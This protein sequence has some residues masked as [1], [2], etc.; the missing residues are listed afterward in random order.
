MFKRLSGPTYF[1]DLESLP[2]VNACT[3]PP[4]SAT[5]FSPGPFSP[6]KASFQRGL[7]EPLRA[8]AS[9]DPMAVGLSIP[10]GFN[11]QTGM[12]TASPTLPFFDPFGLLSH[13][14]EDQ[15]L[16]LPLPIS[17]PGQFLTEDVMALFSA[18][19]YG[20][21]TP[22]PLIAPDPLRH[23]PPALFSRF[24]TG[25]A[26][27]DAQWEVIALWKQDLDQRIG[28]GQYAQVL[29]TTREFFDRAD[30]LEIA[31]KA[32][33]FGIHLVSCEDFIDFSKTSQ[34]LFSQSDILGDLLV[35][36]NYHKVSGNKAG[37]S[38]ILRIMIKLLVGGV[39]LDHEIYP[40]W[41]DYSSGVDYAYQVSN[42]RQVSS[43]EFYAEWLSKSDEAF[44]GV[45]YVGT[46]A[47]NLDS[48]LVKRGSPYL[49][50]LAENMVHDFRETFQCYIHKAR[51]FEDPSQFPKA[52]LPHS[53]P[54]LKQY[55]APIALH[56]GI[57]RASISQLMLYKTETEACKDPHQFVIKNSITT[58]VLKHRDTI[59]KKSRETA[60]FRAIP[61][62]E[63]GV[64]SWHGV[65]GPFSGNDLEV[66]QQLISAISSSILFCDSI[67]IEFLYDRTFSQRTEL[68][69]MV[70]LYL[71]TWFQY[72]VIDD[73]QIGRIIYA[74]W[75]IKDPDRPT[76]EDPSALQKEA[77]DIAR[78]SRNRYIAITLLELGST[79]HRAEITEEEFDTKLRQAN[80]QLLADDGAIFP[81]YSTNT[82][83]YMTVLELALHNHWSPK[84][85]SYF[86][87]TTD[88]F[89]V[90]E[91]DGVK[92][93]VRYPVPAH[94]IQSL[95]EQPATP[96]L[97]RVLHLI[98]P[99]CGDI[100]STLQDCHERLH[101]SW[102]SY[103]ETLQL[104]LHLEK[105]LEDVLKFLRIQDPH[106]LVTH[107]YQGILTQLSQVDGSALPAQLQHLLRMIY[108]IA[109]T[110]SGELEIDLQPLFANAPENDATRLAF[111]TYLLAKYSPQDGQLIA[112]FTQVGKR[113]VAQV[114]A[115]PEL[116]SA[117]IE[118]IAKACHEGLDGETLVT[119]QLANP[120]FFQ[121]AA[122]RAPRSVNGRQV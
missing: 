53:P 37:E 82:A 46:G 8:P 3:S 2:D 121:E 72:E 119:H 29:F 75:L 47:H 48:F 30:I 110:T 61:R 57:I 55:L 80:I 5:V 117:Q 96:D 40:N 44:T 39:Y 104:P 78:T 109:T 58:A 56:K 91:I 36:Y 69:T 23:K 120:W 1:F 106:P 4:P 67:P 93:N 17:R 14:P 65:P 10:N 98:L 60:A 54:Y 100:L 113:I 89:Q 97:T 51:H 84:M 95:L 42:G 102:A 19:S 25:R 87:F 99:S 85:I 49:K 118:V 94:C 26:L 105:R 83:A 74:P 6:K 16:R 24:W 107:L 88:G 28:V 34:N 103:F 79:H 22:I 15:K 68:L 31:T 86:L 11:P 76:L 122:L 101:P 115:G 111:F 35:M 21:E 63:K 90:Q 62:D 43:G 45:G 12:A 18:L 7:P 70:T 64:F 52:D 73:P 92:I 116:F 114:W 81:N 33:E 66:A 71:Q 38:D 77:V 20:S 27:N 41:P 112:A 50:K 108:A 9:E 32:H 59:V 13:W